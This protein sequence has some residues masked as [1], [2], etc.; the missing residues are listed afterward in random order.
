MNEVQ[1]L[2]LVRKILN[3][4]L[5]DAMRQEYKVSYIVQMNNTKL[6]NLLSTI[7]DNNR[8]VLLKYNK[9]I[10]STLVN[11]KISDYQLLCNEI[12]KVL[13]SL[14]SAVDFKVKS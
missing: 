7:Q 3:N 11:T 12:R 14:P 8:K 9:L 6:E 5:Q 2:G 10:K 4:S 13:L 1:F